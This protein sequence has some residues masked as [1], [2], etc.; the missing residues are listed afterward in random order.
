[1]KPLVISISGGSGVGKTTMSKVFARILGEEK[2]L[3]VS[4]DDLHK[5]E[6]RDS[7]WDELTH[8]NVSAN[9]L[10]L[11]DYY[12]KTLCSNESIYRSVYNHTY[13]TF[14]PPKLLKPKP[15]VIN[16]GLHALYS[17]DSRQLSE[18]KIYVDVSYELMTHWKLM[19]DSTERGY[20]TEEILST[21]EKRKLDFQKYIEP[22]KDHADVVVSFNLKST[23]ESLGDIN[24]QIDVG[25]DYHINREIFHTD[26]FENMF[27]GLEE[28]TSILNEFV[29]CCKEVGRDITLVQGK[30]G[31][32]SS[33][34][35]DNTMMIKAS[36]SL[37]KEVYHSNG[38]AMLD[39]EIISNRYAL[40]E[41][42]TE[43][44]MC[45]LINEGTH[46]G[47]KNPSMETAFHAILPGD[48]IHT[49]PLYLS[50]ILCSEEWLDLL[51][52][53]EKANPTYAEWVFIDY[54]TPGNDLAEEI[55]DRKSDNSDV[56]FLKNHGLIVCNHNLN[57]G[58]KITKELNLLAKELLNLPDYE[59]KNDFEDFESYLFPDDVLFSKTSE[60]YDIELA[61]THNY[62][63]KSI[64]EN[65]L[66]P[67]YLTEEQCIS[68]RDSI[69][70][71][72]RLNK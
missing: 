14:D 71:K 68:V 8:L 9:N 36:G 59:E 41:N 65:G 3:V 39:Y 46:T 7:K 22:Q 54:V 58:L 55:I 66:T 16:E 21:I 6:R 72:K 19:R 13:G 30:G 1:M 60:G 56:F 29:R 33:K 57:V 26:I 64:K 4:G 52:K 49:H 25:I 43:L 50:V 37:L 44:E 51:D 67:S 18:I 15:F 2:C 17:D 38:F 61:N 5:Y 23:I 42:M 45:E 27:S 53:L 62:I 31:N 48:V 69:L 24:E 11:G 47:Y 28:Y 70:E 32:I 34:F 40:S 10:D 12:L 63:I 20:T 35:V